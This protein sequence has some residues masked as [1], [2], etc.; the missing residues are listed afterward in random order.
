MDMRILE[1]AIAVSFQ[2]DNFV[3]LKQSK[4]EESF[5]NIT[6][7]PSVNANQPDAADPGLPRIIIKDASKGIA[8]SQL[9]ARLVLRLDKTGGLERQVQSVLENMD[10]FSNGVKELEGE[11]NIKDTALSFSAGVPSLKPINELNPYIFN[12]YSKLEPIGDI[13]ISSFRTGFKT[14][15]N[16]FLGIEL[17]TYMQNEDKGERSS[18]YFLKVDLNNKPALAA[19]NNGALAAQSAIKTKFKSLVDSELDKFFKKGL[20]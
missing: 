9:S 2:Q 11:D 5:K 6:A 4:A 10:L 12:N 18:G 16:L 3:R 19:A 14:E 15:E 7:Q 20:I 13:I 17:G 8:V 1:A